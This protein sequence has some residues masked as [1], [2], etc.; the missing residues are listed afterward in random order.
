MSFE[1][2]DRMPQSRLRWLILVA[3]VVYSAQTAV[4][5][6]FYADDPLLIDNDTAVDVGQPAEHSLSDMYDFIVHSFGKPGDR[7]PGPAENINTLGEVP[8]SS[9]FTNRHEQKAMTIEELRRGPDRSDGPSTEGV[10]MVTEA[11]TEGLTPGFRIRDSRGDI[12]VIK[13]DPPENAEMATA[14]EI[15]STKF[16]YAMGYN[17]PENYLVYLERDRLRV[18]PEAMVEAGLDGEEPMEEEDLDEILERT[19]RSEDGTYRAVAS[20]FLDGRPL[21]PFQYS[22][23]RSDDSNDIFIHEDRRELRGLRVLASWLNHDDSRAINSQDMVITEN[24]QSFIRHHLIDFG[25]TLGS[26]SVA[27]QKHRAGWEYMW[28]PGTALRR[29]ATLGLWDRQW[30]R[31]NYP[32]LPSIGRFESEY[33]KPEEWKPEYPSVAFEKADIEDTYWGVKIVMAFSD[34]EIRAIVKTGGL[35]DPGA[36]AYLIQRLI[37]RRDKIG[38]H[39]FSLVNTADNFRLTSTELGFERLASTYG[40]GGPRTATTVTWSRFD[41]QTGT[42]RNVG[43]KT[44]YSNTSTILPEPVHNSDNENYFRARLSEG[45]HA[46]DIYIRTSGGTLEIVGIERTAL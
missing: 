46:I 36:E 15:I 12:Y 32:D 22:G 45:T 10:W 9:W 41:N 11:K 14:A 16:F 42:T 23:T 8:D 26:G 24:G 7:T 19:H 30:I 2:Y 17:V 28:E 34:A 25:S 40:F 21:G 31:I 18:D 4:A 33:F 37:E 3:V 39:W 38:R 43:P 1:V 35:S 20:K 27:M 44:T 5:Q 29:I 6:K 13:F